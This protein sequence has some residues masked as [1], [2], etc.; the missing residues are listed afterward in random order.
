MLFLGKKYI[1][2]QRLYLSSKEISLLFQ[3]DFMI[4][5]KSIKNKT[6]ISILWPIKNGFFDKKGVRK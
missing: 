1:S 5:C 6:T 2:L 4:V 3:R